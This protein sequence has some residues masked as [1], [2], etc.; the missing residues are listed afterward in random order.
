MSPVY[1]H[2]TRTPLNRPGGGAVRLVFVFRFYSVQYPTILRTGGKAYA[3]Y[4]HNCAERKGPMTTQK[5]P[6]R[7]QR[8]QH[9][10]HGKQVPW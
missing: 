3:V 1:I 5:T 9:S 2:G 6:N 7:I 8:T 4:V 10:S